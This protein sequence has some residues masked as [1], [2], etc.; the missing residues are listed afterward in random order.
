MVAP[1]RDG[2]P[3]LSK[4]LGKSGRTYCWPALILAICL[5][6]GLSWAQTTPALCL[7]HI[8]DTHL[9]ALD[10]TQK[11]SNFL[12]ELKTMQ[13]RPSFIIH[14]GDVT[15]VGDARGFEIY[16]RAAKSFGMPAYAVLGNHDVRWTKFSRRDLMRR[17]S[18]LA[19]DPG[20]QGERYYSFDR[21]KYHFVALDT[22]IPLEHFGL[23]DPQQLR[24]LEQDLAKLPDDSVPIVACHH[25]PFYPGG[26]TLPGGL[27]LLQL[28]SRF[29]GTLI[30]CGHG[31]SS[32]IWPCGNTVVVMTPPLYGSTGGYRMITIYPNQI[33]SRLRRWN[34]SEDPIEQELWR[35]GGPTPAVRLIRPAPDTIARG[36]L[37]IVAQATGRGE[38]HYQIDGGKWQ[39]L[40]ESEGMGKAIVS[41]SGL[42][43][44]THRVTVRLRSLG[45]KVAFATGT[46]SV[47][48]SQPKLVW[49]INLDSPIQARP[50]IA[51]DLVFVATWDGVFALRLADGQAVWNKSYGPDEPV[52]GLATD[53]ERI[54]Y[55]AGNRLYACQAKTGKQLWSLPTKAPFLA[56]PLAAK[57]MI[58]A[59]CGDEMLAV[60][61]LTGKVIWTYPA[62]GTI[63]M[64]PRYSSVQG[65]LLLF[66]AWDNRLRALQAASAV[67]RWRLQIGETIYYSPAIGSPALAGG[68]VIF[69][70]LRRK[71]GPGVFAVNLADGKEL[72]SLTENCGY[73]SP[74]VRGERVYLTSW[75]GKAICASAQDGSVIWQRSLG[76]AIYDSS[77]TVV[78]GRALVAGLRGRLFC[79]DSDTGRLLWQYR[80]GD[81]YIFAPVAANQGMA[82]VCQ[83]EGTV[84]ALAWQ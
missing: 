4:L 73:C 51:G 81:G 8:T 79:L 25:W 10:S 64:A 24:W 58:W 69:T 11:L 80:L 37:E 56:S 42:D 28:L 32:R 27:Q 44:G 19:D 39:P 38:L 26:I 74:E 6:S 1:L 7:V 82:V 29:P 5:L 12:T 60:E 3:G 84:S 59:G 45:A 17:L 33:T 78:G 76:E 31:H 67:E 49:Q 41:T 66:G 72:W 15:E 18:F 35:R 43:P 75:K 14:T 63:Q 34:E 47:P 55:G 2:G 48:G 71:G 23:L 40:P 30:L 65:G 13:P 22:S 57:G 9:P 61:A 68:R 53:G 36:N 77:I 83:M 70:A 54:Y 21:D 20:W 52:G 16:L 46:F 50:V 62:K